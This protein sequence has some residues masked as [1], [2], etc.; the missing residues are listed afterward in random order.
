MTTG[1]K[2]ML[3]NNTEEIVLVDLN[4]RE[5]GHAEKIL[6]HREGLLHRAFSVFVH[7][8]THLLIQKRSMEKYHSGGLWANTCCSHPRKGE[9]L[10]EAVHRRLLEEA[11]FDC[12]LEEQF[13]FTYRTVFSN[14]LTEYEYDHVFLGRYCG[15]VDF[16]PA[17]ASEY[18]WVSFE[19]L[20]E[21]LRKEPQKFC[22]WFI[23]AAP[24]IIRIIQQ[25]E[26]A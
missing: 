22:S 1:E 6:T 12:P 3:Q 2:N 5:T 26:S 19:D 16:D 20:K 4:D 18:R 24:R 21:E 25:K 8:G 23:I 17:E 7:N 10:S 9:M 14:G 13:S 15:E 11:G